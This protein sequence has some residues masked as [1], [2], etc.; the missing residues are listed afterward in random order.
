L[1]PRSP[2]CRIRILLIDKGNDLPIPDLRIMQRKT[3]LSQIEN[4]RLREIM[5]MLFLPRHLGLCLGLDGEQA[6]ENCVN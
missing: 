6:T 5:L 4:S 2:S 3:N 1:E